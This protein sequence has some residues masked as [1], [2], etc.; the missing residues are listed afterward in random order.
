MSVKLGVVAAI[1]VAVLIAA[2]PLYADALRPF[3]WQHY[4]ET[5]EGGYGWRGGESEATSTAVATYEPGEEV[6]ITGVIEKIDVNEGSVTVNGEKIIVRG[7]WI[8]ETPEGKKEVYFDE[9]LT[10]LKPGE[11]ASIKCRVSGKWGLIALEIETPS[12][13]AEKSEG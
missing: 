9:L 1:V 11:K 5:R 7:T 3:I 13:K 6:T 12:L 8:V 2:F 10:M 4:A